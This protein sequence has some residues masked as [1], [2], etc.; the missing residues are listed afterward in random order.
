M[1]LLSQKDVQSSKKKENEALIETNIRLRKFYKDITDKLNVV[2]ENYE[3]EKVA[4]LKDFEEFCKDLISK[5][6]KLLEEFNVLE[7]AIKEKKE[8]YYGLIEKQDELE[9]KIYQ[10]NE[11]H[12]KLD[13]REAF[14]VDLEQKWKEKNLPDN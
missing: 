13:L 9:E 3:P 1:K 12:K 7:R 2:R 4:K 10:V 8:L 11:A 6:S 14:V 5:K